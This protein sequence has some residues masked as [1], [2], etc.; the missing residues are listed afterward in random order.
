MRLLKTIGRVDF[1]GQERAALNTLTMPLGLL[2]RQI[3]GV[4]TP[5]SLQGRPA[6]LRAVFGRLRDLWDVLR[7]S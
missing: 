7:R 5:R 2:L 3:I 1:T 4:G 6:L